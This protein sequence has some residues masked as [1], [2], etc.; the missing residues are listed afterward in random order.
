MICFIRTRD[1]TM[2][3]ARTCRCTRTPPCRGRSGQLAA[4][5][6]CRSWAG[7]T[8]NM[9]ESEFATRT[10]YGVARGWRP[11]EALVAP[12]DHDSG[13]PTAWQRG[14]A[15]SRRWCSST[16]AAT[17]PRGQ[18]SLR[19]GGVILDPVPRS[20][21]GT[22]STSAA[23]KRRPCVCSTR[24]VPT[25]DTRLSDTT[26][27]IAKPGRPTCRP[28]ADAPRSLVFSRG[29]GARGQKNGCRN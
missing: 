23:R 24:R 17:C 9:F 20:T 26:S 1:T 4:C 5:L 18:R 28:L 11:V 19:T 14:G 8:I 3:F 29:L 27:S 2:R 13:F 10:G 21:Q 12:L 6:R 7:Y 22:T 25:P 15:R 16:T